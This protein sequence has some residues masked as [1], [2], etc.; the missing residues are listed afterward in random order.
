METR[1]RILEIATEQFARYG[2]RAVT[3]EDIARQAGV[4]KKTIYQEFSDK[5]DLVKE[6][7]EKILDEDR[8]KLAFIL[9]TEDGVIEHLVKTSK[10]MRERL[11]NM[12]PMVILEIQKYF[13]EAWKMFEAFKVEVIMKDLVK[14]IEKGKELG[15]FRAEIDSEILAKTRVNQIT[16]SFD[17]SN[18]INP[19]HNLADEQM[20]LLDHFLHGIFTEKG[21]LAF[22]T[23]QAIED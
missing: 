16:S 20:V 1:K 3:M 21:R 2:V 19:N 17:P 13:P 8:C 23:Q 6:A 5:K 12:N 9:E 10:M 14:V 7:F 11:Q 15:Y 4:S 18:F 22:T